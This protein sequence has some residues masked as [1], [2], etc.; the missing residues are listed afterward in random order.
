M[1][2]RETSFNVAGKPIP[3]QALM[4]ASRAVDAIEMAGK[5]AMHGVTGT[6]VS[7]AAHS[8]FLAKVTAKYE[9]AGISE[10]QVE[11]IW[12]AL[13]D[14]VEDS[15]NISGVRGLSR[16]AIW[17]AAKKVIPRHIEDAGLDRRTLLVHV[18]DAYDGDL[19]HIGLTQKF[20]GK[21]KLLAAQFTNGNTAGVIAEHLWP[22]LKFRYNPFFQMQEKIEPW[23]L[24][25]QRGAAI[26]K[27]TRMNAE[28]VQL[29]KLYNNFVDKNLI[30]MADND[31]AELA[32]KFGWGKGME[33]ASNA[34]GGKMAFVRGKLEELTEVQGVKQ[35]NMLRTFKKGL[36]R[37]MKAVWEENLPGEWEKMLRAARVRAGTMIDDDEFAIKLAAENLTANRVF[38]KK[39]LDASGGFT[40][41]QAEFAK[42]IQTNQW[43]GPQSLGEMRALNLD[44]VA[45]RISLRSPRTGRDYET[46]MQLREGLASGDLDIDDIRR[47]LR[48]LDADPD[49]IARV[50]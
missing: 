7:H 24:N 28:D 39:M 42:A 41:Y 6:M 15:E 14:K 17:N 45:E 10:G 47:A 18:L 8:K 33:A 37:E 40:G 3:R 31:I 48:D 13:M 43:S 44:A 29:A 20:T 49:Y 34:E 23:V 11:N 30:N 25:A 19:R 12:R 1:P 38:S 46:S 21:A 22:L 2:V 5:T 4:H 9:A 35:L 36:G 27:G 16:D 26:I 50:D 32:R